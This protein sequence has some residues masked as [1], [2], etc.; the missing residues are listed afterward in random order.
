MRRIPLASGINVQHGGLLL[1]GFEV[2]LY[3][4]FWSGTPRRFPILS[5]GPL[6]A[7]RAL[8]RG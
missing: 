7:L 6:D 8:R 2:T 4:R 1:A 3:G 5:A